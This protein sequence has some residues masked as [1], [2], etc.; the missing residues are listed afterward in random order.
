VADRV[1]GDVFH[2]PYLW[3]SD[4]ERGLENPKDRT[5]CLA[6]IRREDAGIAHLVILAI[7]DRPPGSV[8]AAI[9]VPAT[10]I[11]RGGLNPARRAFITISEYNIDTLPFSP[12]YDPNSRTFGR[13]GKLFIALVA[14]SLA[15]AIREGRA[16]KLTR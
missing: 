2:Y 4:H 3:A 7:S 9:E 10:E 12:H 6:F 5:A 11:A 15:R 14:K 8:E 16:R 1:V 13:F